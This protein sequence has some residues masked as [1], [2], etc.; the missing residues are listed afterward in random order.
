[1]TL[2]TQALIQDHIAGAV[3]NLKTSDMPIMPLYDFSAAFPSVAHDFMFIIL[4]ALK[5]PQGLFLFL[6][7]LYTNNRCIGCF[8]G[9]S[10]FLYFICS[11]IIQGCPLSGSIFALAIDALIRL[12]LASLQESDHLHNGP[13][14]FCG[15]VPTTCAPPC[16]ASSNCDASTILFSCV[17]GPLVSLSIRTSAF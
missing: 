1:M 9:V 11:G 10:M 17:S 15:R 12:M 13:P 16:L 4:T 2:D 6:K 3:D 14:R 8:D 7:P 5:F